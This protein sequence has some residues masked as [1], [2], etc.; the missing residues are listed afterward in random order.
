[1]KCCSSAVVECYIKQCDVLY[2]H[3]E[4]A[5]SMV[6]DTQNISRQERSDRCSRPLLGLA[7][8]NTGN[9][10]IASPVKELKAPEWKSCAAYRKCWTIIG[11][12]NC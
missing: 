12:A 6:C 9:E 4:I 10:E 5:K 11:T 1:M 2:H 3:P 7:H 8:F